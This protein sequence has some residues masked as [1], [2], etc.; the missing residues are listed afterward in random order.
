LTKPNHFQAHLALFAANLIY[1][2]NYTI[3]KDVL[4]NHIAP[5]GFIFI[6]VLGAFILF[7]LIWL[8]NGKEK[9]EKRDFNRFLLCAALGVAGNQLMFFKGLSLTSPIHAAIVLTINPIA[10]LLLSAFILKIKPRIT[11]IL[12]IS[13]GLAGAWY[14]IG[15]K[16]DS[17]GSISSTEGDIYILLNSLSYAGY[18]VVAKP[19]LVKYKTNTLLF[20]TFGLGLLMV[21]PFGWQEFQMIAWN[22]MPT[23][24]YWETLFVVF[25]ATFLAYQ[26]NAVGLKSIHPTGVSVYIYLQPVL[27]A[28]IAIS[29]GADRL[30]MVEIVAASLIFTGVYVTNLGNR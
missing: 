16:A 28:I 1:G 7:F 5:F 10:V 4:K 2:A 24:I 26:F 21:I 19:L 20:Y 8:W 9:I 3:A 13:L 30:T 22:T 6:R 27:A 12:G 14:L 18:L 11:T 25:G 29:F 23:I 17:I 15:Y